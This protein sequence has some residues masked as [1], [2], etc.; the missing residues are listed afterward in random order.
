MDKFKNILPVQIQKIH[1]AKQQLKLTDDEY[2]ETLS[3]FNNAFG[4]PCKSS[5][6]LTEDQ[7]NA[8]LNIFR[9]KLGWKEKRNYKNGKYQN[10]AGRD[11]KYPSVG[12][13]E[14]IDA[15]WYNNPAVKSKTDEAL[16]NFIF[17]IL[18][19][20][21]ISFVLKRDVNRLLKAI[22]S[23]RNSEPDNPGDA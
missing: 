15:T 1:I 16:N 11:K 4:H 10:Y 2:R 5:K 21:H 20:N 18:K 6:Q 19:V 23:I 9:D 7:A 14:K 3:A 13:L 22:E 17:R 8:L 12:Q